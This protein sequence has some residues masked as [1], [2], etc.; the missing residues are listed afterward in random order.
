MDAP[1]IRTISTASVRRALEEILGDESERNIVCEADGLDAGAR[2]LIH[3]A[4]RSLRFQRADSADRLRQVTELSLHAGE[5]S[6]RL[7]SSDADRDARQRQ[8]EEL[9]TL[10]QTSEADRD[11]RQRQVQ[12][13]TSLLQASETDRAARLQ[14]VEEL[15]ARL[16]TSDED[17]T[18]RQ[19]QVQA[20]TALLQVSNTDRAARLQQVEELTALLQTSEADRAARLT[21]IEALNSRLLANEPGPDLPPALPTKSNVPLPPNPVEPAVHDERF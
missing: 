20:L 5:I 19:E 15:A 11:A 7:Q 17:R 4:T 16:Q 21:V 8:V 6:A 2:E 10:L 12:E 14:Q 18:A 9:T 13:L 3:T 1:C